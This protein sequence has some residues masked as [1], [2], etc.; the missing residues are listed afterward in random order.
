MG[1]ICSKLDVMDEG[2][3]GKLSGNCFEGGYMC[4]VVDS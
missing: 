3:M 4:D 1:Q 2:L